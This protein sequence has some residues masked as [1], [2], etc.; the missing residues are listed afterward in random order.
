ML[1]P[2]PYRNM[3]MKQMVAN[4]LV[5][6][7]NGIN[8]TVT[9]ALSPA[10][11]KRNWNAQAAFGE[12]NFQGNNVTRVILPH[13]NAD[14]QRHRELEYRRQIAQPWESVFMYTSTDL[15]R[16]NNPAQAS[17]VNQRQLTIP[18]TAGQFYAFMHALSAAFGTLQ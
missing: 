14:S 8:M 7:P 4:R 11:S 9:A 13:D 16:L 6:N 12:K 15:Q 3:T 2:S 5:E 17:F 18:S 10:E 1:T